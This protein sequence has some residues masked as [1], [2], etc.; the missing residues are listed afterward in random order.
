MLPASVL[1]GDQE[2]LKPLSFKM[3]AF[4]GEKPLTNRLLIDNGIALFPNIRINPRGFSKR[5]LEEIIKIKKYQSAK[6][7]CINAEIER[8]KLKNKEE[9]SDYCSKETSDFFTWVCAYMNNNLNGFSLPIRIDDSSQYFDKL[10]DLFDKYLKSIDNPGFIYEDGLYDFIE[11][12]CNTILEIADK[13]IHEDK[14]TARKM[15]KKI[16]SDIKDDEFL[17]S[18]LDDSYSFR[19]VV[20][21]F[22]YENESDE[23]MKRDLT[24]YRT[25]TKGK[26]DNKNL[27]EKV[28][29]MYHLPY[30]L[31]KKASNMR[32]NV[33]GTPALYLCTTTYVCS[34]ECD[35]NEA[36]DDLYASVFVPN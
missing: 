18:N 5:E 2:G 23:I 7:I 16:I 32:F 34:K 10:N 8:Y 31:K 30:Y 26:N 35:C 17:V 22:Y 25:R 20:P 24:F 29:H 12:Q 3:C 19:C 1:Y 6:I 4:Q 27:I 15:L 13:L 36:D 21:T 33:K 9:M 11:C 14:S 28:E